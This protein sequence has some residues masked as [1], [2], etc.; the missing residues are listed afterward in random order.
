VQDEPDGI[1]EP[2]LPVAADDDCDPFDVGLMVLD[3]SRMRLKRGEV[4]SAGER[5]G[6]DEHSDRTVP[7][8]H[9]VD[10]R[11]ERMRIRSAQLASGCHA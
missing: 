11:R 8:D 3:R 4:V 5:V 1:D 7:I 6:V 2:V 9:L 10:H